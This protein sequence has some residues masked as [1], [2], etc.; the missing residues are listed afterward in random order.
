[1]SHTGAAGWR[2][3]WL[4]GLY[5]AVIFVL[6]SF[7]FDVTIDESVPFRDKGIHFLEYAVLGFLC[8]N[9]ARRT[10]PDRPA[11]R[12]AA[13]GAFVASAWGL[14]D[15]LHQAFVP[16]RSAELL[17]WVADTLGSITGAGVRFGLHRFKARSP[18]PVETA[19]ESQ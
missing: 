16:G 8:A 12:T 1:V 17:D 2:A 3:W 9:A 11:W 14:G 6:S 7:H 19:E 15:E 10:F 5:M 13:V 4:P 18:A